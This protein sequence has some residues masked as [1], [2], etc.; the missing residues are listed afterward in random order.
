MY[1]FCMDKMYK[2]WQ[3]FRFNEENPFAYFYTII[4]NRIKLYYAQNCPLDEHGKP[5]VQFVS[6][7]EGEETFNDKD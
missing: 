7:D 6:I 4:D 1:N 5:L 2:T 3:K